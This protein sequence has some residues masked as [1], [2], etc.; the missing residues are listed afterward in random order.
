MTLPIVVAEHRGAH[1]MVPVLG[2]D[3]AWVRDVRARLADFRR[4]AADLPVFRVE[5]PDRV[6]T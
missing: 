4:V 3:A 6:S 5:D 1:S 2:D